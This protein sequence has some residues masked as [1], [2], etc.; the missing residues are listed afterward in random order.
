VGC[1]W[2]FTIKY[3]P[4]GSVDRY[5]AQLVAKGFTQTYGLDYQE[6][7]TPVAKLNTVRV[8]LSLATN[9]DWP[10]YQLDVKNAFL[11]GGLEEEVFMEIS[12]GFRTPHNFNK[13]CKLKKSLYGHKQSPRAWFG[14]FTKVVKEHGHVQGHADHT[15][16]V[17]R[18][19]GRIA[20]LIVYVDDF[21][22]T[23]DDLEELAS[24][25]SFLAK[26]FEVKDLGFL[27]YF[28]GMEV[29]KTRKGIS[30]SQRKYVLDLLKETGML[31]C[32]LADTP[33]EPNYKDSLREEC[34]LVDKGQYQRLVGKLL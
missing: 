30:V 18:S 32:K 1:K 21:I 5:K 31:G 34:S 13:V 27:K 7:F 20:M 23:G 25:K 17:K 11:N 4:D 8:L 19:Q 12:P 33:M 29:A 14:R 22:L 3:Q 15:L 10:L 28:L 2:I 9:C 6:T 16:F 24:L 26:E